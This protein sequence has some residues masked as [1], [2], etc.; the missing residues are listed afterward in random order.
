MSQRLVSFD[1]DRIKEYLFA[2]PVLSDIR[3][4]SG[5]L[6]RL[7]RMDLPGIIR[8]VYPTFDEN[9]PRQCVYVAGGSALVVLPDEETAERAIRAVQRL[10]RQ[11]TVTASI[12]GV[13]VP[14]T[15]EELQSQFGQKARWTGHRLRKRK[16]EKGRGRTLPVAPYMHFCDACAQLPAIHRD[17]ERNEFI[18]RACQIK[19]PGT[20]TA[21]WGLWEK[22]IGVTKGPPPDAPKEW[23]NLLEETIGSTTHKQHRPPDDFDAIGKS[24]KRQ[25]YIALVYA[26]GNRMGQ[27][28][29]RL[30]TVEEYS[31][32]AALVDDLLLRVTYRALMKQVQNQP[33]ESLFEVL[34]A[35]G[36]DLML[37]TT[38]DIAFDVIGDIARDFEQY[39][40]ALTAGGLSLGVGIVIAHARYPIAAMQQ[41]ATDLQKRAKKRSFETGGGSAVDFAVVT[42]A[43]SEDLDRMRDT[44]LT[45]EGFTFPPPGET[46]YRLT[47]RPYTMEEIDSLVEYVRKFKIEGMPHGQLQAMYEALFHSPIHASL[48]AIQTWGRLPDGPRRVLD[49]F[50]RRFGVQATQVPP[51]WR[52]LGDG[53]RDSALGDLVEIYPFL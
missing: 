13:A 18:C 24:A 41:L 14:I 33:G 8:Q 2:T 47:Q 48:A 52:E 32:F 15:A 37:V 16:G 20:G 6:D 23:Q 42:A 26:D 50:F 36:D 40:Q 39:S 25:G 21:R 10:Y 17:A 27:V 45:E 12:T 4:A 5:L 22:L 7:N 28:L 3:E 46:E 9:D 44:V 11:E 34:M 30:E 38:P 29:E 35:G 1:T 51:P 49:G 43:G 31:R 53:S 19:R